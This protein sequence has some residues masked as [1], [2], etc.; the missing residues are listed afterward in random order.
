VS[1]DESEGRDDLA[2]GSV[3]S[4]HFGGIASGGSGPVGADRGIA[5]SRRIV[6]GV[7]LPAKDE[8]GHDQAARRKQTFCH[9]SIV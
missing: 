2:V 3:D 8:A 4:R 6:R 9:M 7:R 5:G 1:G